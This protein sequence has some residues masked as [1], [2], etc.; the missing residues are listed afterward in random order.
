VARIGGDEIA[1]LIPNADIEVAEEFAE[2]VRRRT[3]SIVDTEFGTPDISL[4]WA[5][6]RSVYD[7]YNEV[8]KSADRMMYKEKRAYKEAKGISLSGALPLRRE[9]VKATND[10]PDVPF[11]TPPGGQPAQPGQPTQPA[12]P[13]P[14][15][16]E[17]PAQPEPAPEILTAA[18]TPTLSEPPEQAPETA[19]TFVA[20]E[21]PL[22]NPET[23]SEPYTAPAQPEPEPIG[24]KSFA[25]QPPSQPEQPAPAQPSSE[26][27]KTSPFAWQPPDSKKTD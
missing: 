4:G 11:D 3:N 18:T 14:A 24:V 15:Q 19:E 5:V 16:P 17:Q 7:D 12:Q 13:E 22:L 10:A 1:V 23:P 2:N 27:A 8:F 25:W 6:A 26:S 21:P 9:Q 20:P